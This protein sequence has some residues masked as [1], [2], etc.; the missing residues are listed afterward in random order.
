MGTVTRVSGGKGSSVDRAQTFLRTETRIAVSSWKESLMAEVTIDAL[1]TVQ[2]MLVSSQQVRRTVMANGAVG[3]VI[4]SAFTRV[5][6]NE[7]KSMGKA[8]SR[9]LPETFSKEITETINV[10]AM[11][12]CTG[13]MDRATRASGAMAYSMGMGV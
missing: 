10:T 8:N 12:K 13:L 4:K 3:W 7:I 1:A 5:N 6:S 11:E 2:I 9:G